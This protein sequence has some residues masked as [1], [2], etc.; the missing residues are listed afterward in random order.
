M[1]DHGPMDELVTLARDIG[2]R[3]EVVLRRRG[4]GDHAVDELI[5]N[6]AFAM[7]S[8]ETSSERRLARLAYELGPVGGR[9]LV[10]GLGLGYTALEALEA[11]VGRLE[12]VELEG[13]LVRWARQGL[14][15]ALSR[16][17][18]DPRVNLVV[19][20]VA[21][22]LARSAEGSFDAVAL[23]VDNGP[24]FLIHAENASLYT[25]E[26]LSLAFSRLAPGGRLAIWCQGPAPEL[27]RSLTTIASTAYQHLYNVQRGRRRFSYAIYTLDRPLAWPHPPATGPGGPE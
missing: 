26:F 17:A 15:P 18:T 13:L 5:V 14:T 16:V 25:P 11:S 4:R 27:L 2:S 3:G 8:A 1:R 9:M 20:D 10:G 7:D 12:V 21:E 23:D 24:D 19:G 22:V 6:G